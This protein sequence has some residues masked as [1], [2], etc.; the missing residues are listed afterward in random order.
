MKNTLVCSI[1]ILLSFACKKQENAITPENTIPTVKFT[2]KLVADYNIDLNRADSID[3]YNWDWTE[4]GMNVYFLTI[5]GEINWFRGLVNPFYDHPI[6]GNG[7]PLK[8]DFYPKDGWSLIKRDFGN[9][10]SVPSYPYF[11]L[12][13]ENR[14]ILR[15]CILNSRDDRQSFEV[16]TLSFKNSTYTKS[17]TATTPILKWIVTQ[18]DVSKVDKNLI[19]PSSINLRVKEFVRTYSE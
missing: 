13:N 6:Y 9:E 18:F 14:G 12:Y 3:N 10:R 11:I 2:D 19:K 5:F 15:T 7:D 16:V 4:S 17:D 8:I 1:L